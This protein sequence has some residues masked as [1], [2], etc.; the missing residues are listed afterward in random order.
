M[1]YVCHNLL[2]DEQLSRRQ[3]ARA[4]AL[5]GGCL[6]HF[7]S[8]KILS[9]MF[10]LASSFHK[11]YDN[12]DFKVLLMQ[13]EEFMGT[14]NKGA[15]RARDHEAKA[16]EKAKAREAAMPQVKVTTHNMKLEHKLERFIEKY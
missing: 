8:S 9:K 15:S 11:K 12:A 13:I 6:E 14:K 10:E 7:S 1:E 4:L 2:A 3:Q 5:I 16:Q